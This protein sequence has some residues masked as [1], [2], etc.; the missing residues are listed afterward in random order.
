MNIIRRNAG[1][2]LG[3]EGGGSMLGYA[4][5]AGLVVVVAVWGASYSSGTGS[6]DIPELLTLPDWNMF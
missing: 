2:F 1:K 4:V 6:W 5:L 3:D